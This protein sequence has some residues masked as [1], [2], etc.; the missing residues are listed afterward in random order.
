MNIKNSEINLFCGIRILDEL[1]SKAAASNTGCIT[2]SIEEL[3]AIKNE[4][5]KI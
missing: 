3:N 4:I 2:V 5:E 1:K